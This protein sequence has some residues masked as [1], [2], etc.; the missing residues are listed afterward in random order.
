ASRSAA[1]APRGRRSPVAALAQRPWTPPPA[2]SLPP[3]LPVSDASWSLPSVVL[4]V[5]SHAV[6]QHQLGVDVRSRRL[7]ASG[8]DVQM[9]ITGPYLFISAPMFWNACS[10]W[11]WLTGQR[12]ALLCGSPVQSG[13]PGWVSLRS[14]ILHVIRLK[15]CSDVPCTS[16]SCQA[17]GR[18]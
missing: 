5:H 16:G 14:P 15:L 6:H 3:V 18:R 2:L 17:F 11:D 13:S 4:L 10:R 12:H 8:A 7:P 9:L 1:A